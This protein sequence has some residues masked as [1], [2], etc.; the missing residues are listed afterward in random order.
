M[1]S[2]FKALGSLKETGFHC[3]IGKSLSDQAM[4]TRTKRQIKRS[5]YECIYDPHIFAYFQIA[6]FMQLFT[7]SASL[8]IF[9]LRGNREESSAY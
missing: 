3:I 8:F 5:M 7:N 6:L 9:V 2:G 1:L 4:V